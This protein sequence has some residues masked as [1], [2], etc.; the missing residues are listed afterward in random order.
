MTS[1]NIRTILGSMEFGRRLDFKQSNLV[2]NEFISHSKS[3]N[4]TAEVDSA[5]MYAGGESEKLIGRSDGCRDDVVRIATKANPWGGNT[6]SREGVRKQLE[7]SLQR[8]KVKSV[9]LFYLHAPDYK[10]PIVE[11]LEA[12]NQMHN[13]GKFKE[14]GL[15]N[16][17]AWQV[18]QIHT[19]CS[20]NSWV[21]PTVYQGMYNCVTR[22]VEKE[23]FP[24]LRHFNMRFYAYNPLAGGIL[25]GKHKFEDVGKDEPGRFFGTG[26]WVGTYR[27]RFWRKTN[28]DLVEEI[29]VLLQDIYGGEVTL[30]E[31]AYRWLFHHSSLDGSK[32]DGVIIGCSTIEQ[33]HANIANTRG[34]GLDE[35]ITKVM[36]QYW[37]QNAT[38]CPDYMR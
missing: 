10:V 19:I 24:C 2:M 38:T 15:S 32:G 36:D 31:A 37:K 20:T 23:L 35:R 26:G 29:K 34:P 4:T 12:V 13:E 33:Y 6:L 17:S 16:Y 28:F 14:L 27:Q 5:F 30:A 9:H 21:V 3:H 11:T 1:S 22:M 25:T 18:A 7:T 8:M